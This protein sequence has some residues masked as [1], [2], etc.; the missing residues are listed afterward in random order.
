MR[1]HFVSWGET[2][3]GDAGLAAP[4]DAVG[5]E[6]PFAG[7]RVGEADA[8]AGLL[9]S[10]DERFILF[11]RPC[12]E[13]FFDG[14]DEP[15]IA[16]F[17]VVEHFEGDVAGLPV[18]LGD[19]GAHLFDNGI[20]VFA[21]GD[22][23]VDIECTLVGDGIDAGCFDL[24]VGGGN[25]AVAEEG[26]V[27]QLGFEAA[28]AFEQREGFVDGVVAEVIAGGVGAFAFGDRFQFDASFVAAVDLHFG[29]F[30]DDDKVG[31]DAFVLDEGVGRDAVAPFFHIAEVVGGPPI[32]KAEAAGDGQ[33]V[34]H[35]G[36]AAFFV[37]GAA[38]VEDAVFDFA[39]ERVPFPFVFSAD[40]NGIDVA[41]VDE[42]ALA[43][44]YFADGVT[45]G[46][47]PDFVEAQ[48]AQF[49]LDAFTDWADLRVDR[50]D[51]ADLAEEGDD[52]AAVLLDGGLDRGDVDFV[53]GQAPVPARNGW[54]Q[55]LSAPAIMPSIK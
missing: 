3:T 34:D 39:F 29:W 7:G 27:A 11:E 40:A 36:R 49:G 54:D 12:G 13:V 44:A 8:F 35:G 5:A 52:V 55:P 32:E 46:V 38:G 42:Y 20:E 4:V 37:A 53:H 10:L 47:E 26:V 25:F 48:F 6:I 19:E 22:A 51:G 41:V 2:D 31:A 9:A 17:V 24:D 33:A 14:E 1:G 50:G 15:G 23:A 21:K 45:H 18:G 30:A 43:V 28:D 16:R